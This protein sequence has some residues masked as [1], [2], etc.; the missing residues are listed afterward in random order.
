MDALLHSIINEL[1]PVA[2]MPTEWRRLL[3]SP[4]LVDPYGVVM[5]GKRP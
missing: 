3:E 2:N 4:F 1:T 5:H